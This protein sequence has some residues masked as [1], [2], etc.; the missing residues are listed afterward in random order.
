MGRIISVED[1]LSL[2][3]EFRKEGKRVVFTNGC[4]D[5]IHRGHIDYLTKAKRLGEILVVGLNSDASVQRIKGKNRP[6]VKGEDRALILSS[7]VCVDYVI[8]FEE[9][10][11]ENLIR[12][13]KPDILVKGADW[14][15][16]AIVG[17]GFVKSYGGKVVRIEYLKGYSTSA[18]I[19]KI[20]DIYCKKG[21]RDEETV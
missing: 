7:L 21:Y 11:P 17:S 4:F 1:F 14:K 16:E 12:A 13:V 6:I 10:T 9:D 20:I 19:N 18:I 8:F 2:R 5:I 3:D 15:E